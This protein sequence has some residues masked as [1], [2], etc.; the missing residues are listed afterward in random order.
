MQGS[1]FGFG[2]SVRIKGSNRFFTIKAIYLLFGDPTRPQGF[3]YSGE[4]DK[5]IHESKLDLASAG[6][7][8]NTAMPIET[9]FSEN[10]R[11][12]IKYKKVTFT[13]LSIESGIPRSSC[14][15]AAYKGAPTKVATLVSLAKYFGVSMDKLMFGNITFEDL[16]GSPTNE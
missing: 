14:Y 9:R 11:A 13:Q 16:S 1:K 2:D 10:L 5:D 15:D 6:K 7:K 3:Y 12:L 4:M 8:L